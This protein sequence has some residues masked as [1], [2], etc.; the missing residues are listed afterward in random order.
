MQSADLCVVLSFQA[1][2]CTISGGFKLISNSY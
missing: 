1:Q 2:K